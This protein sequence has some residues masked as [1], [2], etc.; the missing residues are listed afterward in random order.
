MC[1]SPDCQHKHVKIA[2]D[3]VEA[4]LQSLNQRIPKQANSVRI[5]NSAIATYLEYFAAQAERHAN[6][7]VSG[8]M[9]IGQ[10]LI[11]MENELYQLHFTMYAIGAGG[12]T[13]LDASDIDEINAIVT[14]QS[15][16]LR[17]WAVQLRQEEL[18]SL[19]YMVNRSMLYGAD[20]TNHTVAVAQ[21]RALG[22]PRLP[23][24]PADRTDCMVNCKCRWRINKLEG[25]GN[26]NCFWVMGN[27][28][29]CDTC[30]ARARAASPLRIRD[31][32]ILDANKWQ[33][34]RLYA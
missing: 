3:V 15:A 2:G 6:D 19:E 34:G 9:D 24:Y 8:K 17:R 30:L 32:I 26:Y 12:A 33:D 23:F 5:D 16:Y 7:L 31:G 18:P 25:D 1:N 14:N 27:A 22:M 4:F 28:E 10:W 20:A 11:V 21:T 29:H 13:N